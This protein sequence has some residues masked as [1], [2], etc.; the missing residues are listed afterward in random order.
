MPNIIKALSGARGRALSN[1]Y[2]VKRFKHACD[3]HVFL[4]KGDNALHWHELKGYDLKSGVYFS[5][6]SLGGVT[7]YLPESMLR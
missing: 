3:M 6:T 4:C 2:Q 7:R 1:R 5:Q